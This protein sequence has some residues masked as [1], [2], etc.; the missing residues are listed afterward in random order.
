[1]KAINFTDSLTTTYTSPAPVTSLVFT[2]QPVPIPSPKQHLIRIH[3]TAITPYELSWPTAGFPHPEPRIPCHDSAGTIVSSPPGSAF[4]PGDR[5]FSLLPFIGQGGMAEFAVAEPQ[6]LAKIPEGMDWIQAA[7]VPRAS[8]TSWQALK[9]RGGGYVKPGMKVLITGAT[10]AVG[11]MGVQIARHLTGKAGKVIAVGGVGSE[12]L[13][14]LGADVLVNYRE[15]AHWEEVVRKDGLVDVVYDCLGGETLERCLPLVKDNSRVV[16]IGSPPPDWEV[17]QGWKEA[18][19]RGV[20]GD[21]FILEESGQQ[22]SEIADMWL[23][24]KIKTSV[25]LIVDGLAE[26]NVRE[27]WLRGLKGGLA[28][29]VVVKIDDDEMA[30]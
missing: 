4:Q 30:S 3:A 18:E 8:L 23:S 2:A 10:G 5:V 27:G 20:K 24:G 16:T 26:E 12:G 21:F 14:A 17:L 7:S 28:G 25:G 13:A 19:E 1:M 9:V 29:S 11:R 22:L 6:F 15:K